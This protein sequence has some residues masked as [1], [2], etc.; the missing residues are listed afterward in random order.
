MPRDGAGSASPRGGGRSAARSDR[1]GSAP[2]PKLS[3]GIWPFRIR[4]GADCY[5]VEDGKIRMQTIHYTVEDP[6][7]RV[8]IRADGTRPS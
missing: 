2:C 6:D 4:D 7:G 3:R 8:L 5:L 1:P